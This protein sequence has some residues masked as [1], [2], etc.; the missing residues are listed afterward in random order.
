MN[1]DQ[2]IID[3]SSIRLSIVDGSETANSN[4]C[5]MT[6][7]EARKIASE[8]TEIEEYW[9]GRSLAARNSARRAA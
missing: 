4:E 3:E 5:Q 7:F 2:T 9:A 8:R 1:G 6:I